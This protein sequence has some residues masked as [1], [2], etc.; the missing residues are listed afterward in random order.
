MDADSSFRKRGSE[1]RLK[2]KLDC[3]C[4][5][6]CENGTHA[7][8]ERFLSEAKRDKKLAS[9]ALVLVHASLLKTRLIVGVVMDIA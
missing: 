7:K 3:F 6:R 4:L 9:G 8:N 5:V 2:A 1:Y